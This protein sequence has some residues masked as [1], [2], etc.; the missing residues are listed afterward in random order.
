MFLIIDV[1]IKM[2]ISLSHSN[3]YLRYIYLLT[4]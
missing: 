3:A 2:S 4:Y 1:N